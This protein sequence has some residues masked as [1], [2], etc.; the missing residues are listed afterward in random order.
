MFIFESRPY[1]SYLLL[2]AVGEICNGSVFDP[3][4]VTI[5]LSQQIT[6]VF[7]LT[8]SFFDMQSL[9]YKMPRP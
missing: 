9:N 4:V 6:D 3:A 1:G 2:A 8:F 5:R 7:A